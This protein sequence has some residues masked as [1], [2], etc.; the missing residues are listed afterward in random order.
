MKQLRVKVVILSTVS[1]FVLLSFLVTGMN[2]LNFDF[3]QTEADLLLDFLSENDGTFPEF[4]HDPDPF[5]D[6]GPNSEDDDG[7]RTED[8]GD[9]SGKTKG[10]RDEKKH[11][12][13]TPEAP[14]ESR[15]FSVVLKEDGTVLTAETG[16]IASVDAEQA[17]AYAQRV[18]DL[19][20]TRGF[21]DNFRY[22]VLPV[23]EEGDTLYIFLDRGNALEDF[24]QF[25][26]VST[27]I[28][29][30]GFLIVFVVITII[31]GRLIRPIAQSY[32]KQ[33][34]FITDAGH[35]LKTPLTVI[36]A[37]VDLLEM[38]SGTSE[39]LTDIRQ[40]TH[41]LATLMENL[42]S[43]SRMEESERT[44]VATA[45]PLSEVV[46]ET[47]LSFKGLAHS[48]EQNM[49]LEIQ[50]Q[51]RINGEQGAIRQLVSLLTDNAL[52]Y[53]PKGSEILF[54]LSKQGRSVQLTVTNQVEKPLSKEMLSQI[55]DRFYRTDPSRNSETG[56]HG[57][58]LSLAKAIVTA[59]GGKIYGTTPREDLFRIVVSL[60]LSTKAES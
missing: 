30:F 55:F 6:D 10:D 8:D 39:C 42:V 5:D 19:E 31:S 33:R 1:V 47:V 51:L 7:P 58:G 38:E 34:R 46:R 29:F 43:L 21:I 4:R 40:Q 41:R 24:R 15:F 25:L 18:K 12:F 49:E 56:G 52:K 60:P 3:I 45:V 20:K 36:S 14:Y 11:N 2:L 26:L 13:L 57:I 23:Q 27:S 50:P 53:A 37:N 59:H 44:I 17:V 22:K 28:S 32:E 9:D 48:Q 54:A 16:R 35:E